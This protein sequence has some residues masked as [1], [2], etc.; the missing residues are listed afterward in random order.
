MEIGF[1]AGVVKKI[2]F[3]ASF[4]RSWGWGGGESSTRTVKNTAIEKV[5][6]RSKVKVK[7]TIMET[8]ENVPYTAKYKV[9]YEDGQTKIVNDEGIMK[10][11][12]IADNYVTSSAPESID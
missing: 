6:P 5:P 3:E 7:M 9:T 4:S 8:I 2:G 11:S 12:F 1:D 10:N